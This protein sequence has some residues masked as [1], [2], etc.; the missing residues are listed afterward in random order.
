MTTSD[1][2]FEVLTHARDAM[3]DQRFEAMPK[4]KR[5]RLRKALRNI[6]FALY[7]DYNARHLRRLGSTFDAAFNAILDAHQHTCT[8]KQ[9]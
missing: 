2:P 4:K 6:E 9:R 5:A 8:C 7:A 3:S 1:A